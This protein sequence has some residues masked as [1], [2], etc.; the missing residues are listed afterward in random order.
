MR[1]VHR[2]R[3]RSLPILLIISLLTLIFSIQT[4]QGQQQS[5]QLDRKERK[6]AVQRISELVIENYVFAD[7][8][9][10]SAQH[11]Q[12]RLQA[13]DYDKSPCSY[14]ILGYVQP[15]TKVGM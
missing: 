4:S 10:K 13:D 9:E 3:E 7:V 5:E 11:I 2:H 6:V 12:A 8:G 1:K 15:A 14:L